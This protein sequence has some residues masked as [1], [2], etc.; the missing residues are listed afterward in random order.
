M[1][2]PLAKR[3]NLKVDL[4]EMQ[5]KSSGESDELVHGSKPNFRANLKCVCLASALLAF[6]GASLIYGEANI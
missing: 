3:T 4:E 6:V 5:D 2:W 1:L